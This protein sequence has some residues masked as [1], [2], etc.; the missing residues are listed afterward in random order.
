MFLADHIDVGKSFP[1]PIE[2]GDVASHVAHSLWVIC[3]FQ[4]F[5]LALLAK[6][7]AFPEQQIIESQRF[8]PDGDHTFTS[9]LRSCNSHTQQL[10]DQK[11]E[12]SGG[13]DDLVS[14]HLF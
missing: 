9:L 7:L 3:T 1:Y 2:H 14:S 6:V 8:S 10:K 12:R 13:L 11:Y 4:G 5:S